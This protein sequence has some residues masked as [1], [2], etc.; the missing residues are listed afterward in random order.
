MRH[1]IVLLLLLAAAC[2][3]SPDPNPGDADSATLE[4][5]TDS[6]VRSLD[7]EV[8]DTSAERQTG[9]MGRETLSPFDGMAFIWSDP[10]ESLFWMKD[11]LIP[12]S[13]AFWDQDG[14]IV[15]IIDMP[16]CRADPCPTYGP[17]AAY[18]GAVEVARGELER[19]GVGV[20]DT[21]DLHPRGA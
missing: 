7:V 14:R 20:G 1:A 15:S 6:G 2:G 18:V 8:A 12:L 5:R 19:R 4:I 21:V 17:G 13:I 3:S 9:L 16:P 11:T 10:V